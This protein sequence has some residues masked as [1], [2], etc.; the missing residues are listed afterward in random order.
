MEDESEK[1][2]SMVEEMQAMRRRIRELESIAAGD[3]QLKSEI[4]ALRETCGSLLSRGEA[5]PVAEPCGKTIL[6]VEDNDL[7]RDFTRMILTQYGFTVLE[8]ESAEEAVA[9]CK[10]KGD[11]I[12]LM[13]TDIVMP[14]ASGRELLKLLEPQALEMKVLFM[15]G[16]AKD[17]IAHH[18]VY[19]IID[20]G[21]GFIQKPFSAEELIEMVDA[22]LR[23]AG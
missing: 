12:A 7:F 1:A 13:L 10:A 21:A 16:Y 11:R 20:S 15:S 2:I 22:E 17:V 6:V 23:A 8:A 14:G 5:R 18:D 4:E 19:D 3:R 9:I